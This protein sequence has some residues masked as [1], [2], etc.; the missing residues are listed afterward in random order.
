MKSAIR[1]FVTIYILALCVSAC[2]TSDE[3]PSTFSSTTSI[4]E[5]KS[6]EESVDCWLKE[7]GTALN[8]SY[9]NGQCTAIARLL[10]DAPGYGKD[11]N[12][13]AYGGYDYIQM[14][15]TNG[16]VF[17]LLSEAKDRVQACNNMVLFGKAG[18]YSFASVG[19]TVVVVNIDTGN[20]RID[21]LDQNYAGKGLTL[22]SAKISEIKKNAY[23]IFASCKNGY[24]FQ[25]EK[26]QSSS[27]ELP[28]KEDSGLYV[29]RKHPLTRLFL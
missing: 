13:Q 19:H 7:N 17:P 2:T 10:T 26:C 24:R 29:T 11:S 6:L 5:V 9:G 12:G 22:R 21:W 20:D 16:L 23:V 1:L 18:G 3:S 27:S 28:E 8:E 15:E 4:S 14:K 25:S